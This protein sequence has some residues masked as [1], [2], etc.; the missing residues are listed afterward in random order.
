MFSDDAEMAPPP[1]DLR[2][3]AE[4]SRAAGEHR[5]RELRLRRT[6]WVAGAVAAAVVVA[7]AAA[8]IVMPSDGAGRNGGPVAGPG[9][10]SSATSNSPGLWAG[11]AVPGNSFQRCTELYS[12]SALPRVAYAA[13]D[14]TVATVGDMPDV[15]GYVEVTFRVEKW[16]FGGTGASVTIDMFEPSDAQFDSSPSPSPSPSPPPPT[17]RPGSHLLVSAVVPDPASG[18]KT[19][20]DAGCGLTRFYSEDMAKEFERAFAR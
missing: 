8:A 1:T 16:F 2:A 11:Q 9:P 4:S 17:F 14:G 13:F 19:L 12:P 10:K 3:L 5:R 6:A 20:R 18:S 15:D 7:I